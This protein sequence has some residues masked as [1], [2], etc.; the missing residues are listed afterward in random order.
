L[1]RK[2][3]KK[4]FTPMEISGDSLQLS[5]MRKKDLKIN[6]SQDFVEEIISSKP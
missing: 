3:K 2:L 4:L 5:E 1:K 6:Q